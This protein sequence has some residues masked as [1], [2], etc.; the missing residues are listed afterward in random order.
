MKRVKLLD[1]SQVAKQISDGEAIT[2]M[3]SSGVAVPEVLLQSIE[4]HYIEYGRPRDLTVFFPIAVGDTYGIEGLEHLAHEGLVKRLIGGSYTVGRFSYG[5]SRLTQMVLQD[6]VEAYN[7]PQGVMMQLLREIARKSPGL[8]TKVG[9]G[10]FVDPRLCGGRL[11]NITKHSYTKLIEIDSEEWLLYPSISLDVALLRGST[12]DEYGNIS[13]EHEGTFLGAL[14]QAIAVHNSGGRVIVQVKRL[15][16][17]GSIPP[18]QVRI[19]GVFVDAVVV[20]EN[21]PQA[22]LLDYNPG[23]SGELRV[24][25]WDTLKWP[26]PEFAQLICK[27]VLDELDDG[28]IVCVGYGV[29]GFLPQF[30]YE[31]GC[32]PDVTFVIEQGPI[33]GIPLAGSRFGISVNPLAFLDSPSNFDFL[34]GGGFDVAILA[35][36]EVDEG[37]NVNVHMLPDQIPGCGGFMNIINNARKL[38]FCGSFTATGL[39]VISSDGTVSILEEGKHIRFRKNI[40]SITFPAHRFRNRDVLYVTERCVFKLTSNGLNLIEVF[41]GIDVKK[42]VLSAMEFKPSFV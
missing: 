15:A 13:F 2:V 11:N 33:G 1:P 8:I 31:T 41:P 38:I 16:S 12:A 5:R 29:P 3:A 42:H 30:W 32:K 21:Q 22:T 34:D 36:A 10:T 40:R 37:G 25:N 6:K 24:A 4:Q 23:V 14:Q 17:G 26:M 27:R 28:Y 39:K 19:P 35:F 9:L 18:Q 20:V 7:L